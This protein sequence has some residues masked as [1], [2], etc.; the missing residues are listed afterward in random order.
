MQFLDTIHL[1]LKGHLHWSR[2]VLWG[3]SGALFEEVPSNWSKI[4]M[5]LISVK[6]CEHR[7]LQLRY[8]VTT[9]L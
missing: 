9:T 3:L 7:Y 8:K 1:A 6:S 4:L 5:F 2:I